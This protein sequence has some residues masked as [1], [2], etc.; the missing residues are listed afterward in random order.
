MLGLITL[1]ALEG[2]DFVMS[3]QATHLPHV[4]EQKGVQVQQVVVIA[5][6]N[7][8]GL[9][10]WIISGVSLEIDTLYIYLTTAYLV[11]VYEAMIM[12]EAPHDACLARYL[13]LKHLSPSQAEEAVQGHILRTIRYQMM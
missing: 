4:E 8:Y 11:Q 13:V 9:V 6:L 10:L 12:K 1:I 2:L 7:W 5:G 3:I